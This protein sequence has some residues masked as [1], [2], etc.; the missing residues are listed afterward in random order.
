MWPVR[1]F[2]Y[3]LSLAIIFLPLRVAPTQQDISKQRL[4]AYY[5][6]WD[7][8]NTPPYTAADIPYHKLTHI[9]QAFLLLDTRKMDGSL[10]APPEFSEPDLVIRAHEAGIKVLISIGG[11]DEAQGRAFSTIVAVP[12]HRDNLV[13]NLVQSHWRL[14][15]FRPGPAQHSSPTM[16]SIPPTSKS[17][18][19]SGRAR[20]AA[21]SCGKSV[22]IT[23]DRRRNC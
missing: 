19:R 23:T 21:F 8:F 9:C 12:G 2:R 11:G 10:V 16:M 1:Y 5:A 14:I 20:S 18:T 22:R 7:Q 13:F 17:P 3:W 15:S 6:C 4:L